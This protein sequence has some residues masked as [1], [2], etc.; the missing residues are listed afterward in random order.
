MK[1]WD[2]LVFGC[3]KPWNRE[4]K[5]SCPRLRKFR[6]SS[7]DSSSTPTSD[8]GIVDGATRLTY[9]LRPSWRKATTALSHVY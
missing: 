2:T 3:S 9:V 7:A 8:D 6:E 4:R 1:L 5:I